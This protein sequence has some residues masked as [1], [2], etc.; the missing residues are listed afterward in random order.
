MHSRLML[1]V[2][3]G[4]ICAVVLFCGVCELRAQSPATYAVGGSVTD[5]NHAP[6]SNA[7]LILS[8]K[9]QRP[10][11]AR[12]G[13]D[14]RFAFADVGA[15]VASVTARRL[16]YKALT[17]DLDIGAL[18]GAT[19]VDFALEVV[20][21]ELDPVAI[22]MTSNRMRDFNLHKANPS[23]GRFFEQA[24]IEKRRPA[25]VSD[26]FRTVP[27]V[28]LTAAGIGNAVRLR[29]CKPTVWIDGI[30]LPG[31]E[32]DEVAS[33]ADIAGIELY[34]S[35][36]GLPAEYKDQET[37]ACGVIVLWSKSR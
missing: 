14:G 10:R 36:A 26:L 9:G 24:E 34:T 16:G 15:G 18:T 23:F 4:L 29:G 11:D 35:W 22:S 13:N 25:Y 31:A 37:R 5:H 21:T 17:I 8:R 32:L 30:R 19:P 33:A 2:T 1:L 3:N 27:G 6:I 12:T 7:E 20:P 28:S